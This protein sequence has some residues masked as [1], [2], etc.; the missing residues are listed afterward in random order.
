VASQTCDREDTGS[1][2]TR[3]VRDCMNHWQKRIQIWRSVN[4]LR[5][6]ATMGRLLRRRNS[7]RHR[8][9]LM[10][11][12]PAAATQ[13][14]HRAT[15]GMQDSTGFHAGAASGLHEEPASHSYPTHPL[16]QA[17][18]MLTHTA[19]GSRTASHHFTVDV[20]EYFQVSALEPLVPR[21]DW[22][23]LESRVEKSTTEL[24]ELLGRSN[25]L[26]TF[27]V[28]GCVAERHPDLVQA[29]AEAGHEVASHG[30]DHRKVTAC[31]PADFRVD[32][33]RSKL[34]LEDLTGKPVLGFRAPSFSLIE[35]CEWALDILIEEGYTYDSSLFPIRRRGYGYRTAARDPHVLRRSGG[36]LLEFPPATIRV[37]GM[38]L[39]AG[40]GAYFRLLPYAVTDMALAGAE[41]R[42]ARATFYIHPWELDPGQPRL[43]VPL[44]TR[45]RHYGG[46]SRMKERLE[47]LLTEHRFQSVELTLQQEMSSPLLVAA[48]V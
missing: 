34:V 6:V 13:L 4:V 17:I 42:G 35:G 7:F 41:A 15:A 48:G 23:R 14:K 31:T 33:R 22:T 36:T 47:R 8:M 38:N 26:G 37:A 2:G 3:H 10:G 39:P 43:P 18:L 27:F 28:L 45:V 30:W 46:L 29:I 16:Q 44:G 40:G 19:T 24:L 5:V 9:W 1:G 32:V 20:E 12:R 11:N 25:T 21:S